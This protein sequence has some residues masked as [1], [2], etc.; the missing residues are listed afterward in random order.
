M[1]AI[2]ITIE[3]IKMLG[4][5]GVLYFLLLLF[6]VIVR[7]VTTMICLAGPVFF[8]WCML[9]A[10]RFPDDIHYI[11]KFIPAWFFNPMSLLLAPLIVLPIGF[12]ISLLYD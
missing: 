2:E 6:I 8:L 4:V 7:G 1:S 3:I 5:V 9:A 12:L 10:E 11:N